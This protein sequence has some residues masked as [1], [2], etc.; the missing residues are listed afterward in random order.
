MSVVP[1]IGPRAALLLGLLAGGPKTSTELLDL[2]DR[3]LEAKAGGF[4]FMTVRSAAAELHAGGIREIEKCLVRLRTLDWARSIP[5]PEGG[6][7][8]VATQ[9]SRPEPSA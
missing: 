9:P 5:D 8:W 2:I 3:A 1:Q 6:A 4:A 7:L